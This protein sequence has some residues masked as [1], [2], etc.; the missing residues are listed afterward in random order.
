MGRLLTN[1]E[2]VADYGDL[3]SG[4][5]AGAYLDVFAEAPLPADSPL[6]DVPTVLISP[7][8]SSASR[9]NAARIS[10][11]FLRNVE[12]WARGEPLENE[13]RER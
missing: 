4:R 12:R 7:H 5:L 10:E 9:G 11:L 13:V 8:D 2:F 6:W 3:P 1:V